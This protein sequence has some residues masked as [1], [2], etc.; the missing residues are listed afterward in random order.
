MPER[1]PFRRAMD[2]YGGL[3]DPGQ[4]QFACGACVLCRCH[5][6]FA[7]QAEHVEPKVKIL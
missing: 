5:E 7:F 2:I 4:C 1:H 6:R 3:K